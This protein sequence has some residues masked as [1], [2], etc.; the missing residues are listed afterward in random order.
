MSGR[1]ARQHRQQ[2][3]K[4][5]PALR[6][7][8][9]GRGFLS[10]L[11]ML[12]FS[13]PV[14]LTAFGATAASEPST[15]AVSGTTKSDTAK[16]GTAKPDAPEPAASLLPRAPEALVLVRPEANRDLQQQSVIHIHEDSAGF[17]WLLTQ[18]AVHRFDGQDLI[19]LPQPGQTDAARLLGN[20]PVTGI[21]NGPEGELWLATMGEGLLRFDPRSGEF[22]SGAELGLPQSEAG[23]RIRYLAAS[24]QGLYWLTPAGL[25]FR[26]A[27]GGAV[28]TL[29]HEGQPIDAY[30]LWTVGDELWV[31]GVSGLLYRRGEAPLSRLADAAVQGD[32]SVLLPGR[33]G[34]LFAFGSYGAAR[35]APGATR[36]APLPIAS[37]GV[38]RSA[39]GQTRAPLVSSAV[40][41]ADGTLWLAMPGGGLLERRSDGREFVHTHAADDPSGIPEPD[42]IALALD[43]AGRLWIGSSSRGFYHRAEGHRWLRVLREPAGADATSRNN[44]FALADDGAGG[45]WIGTEGAGLKHRAA[46][47][48]VSYHNAALQAAGLPATV[49]RLR[50]FGGRLF[51]R[52]LLAQGD[53]LLVGGAQALWRYWPSQQRAELVLP[54]LLH[55]D[56]FNAGVRNLRAR[57]N[58]EV[59][60]ASDRSGLVVLTA[61]GGY[62]QY[63]RDGKGPLQLPTNRVLDALEDRAGQVWLAT[64]IGLF[65]LRDGQAPEPVAGDPERGLPSAFV[66]TLLET[67]TG[68]LWV[69]TFGGI[70]RLQDPA[71]VAPT[72][73]RYTREQGLRDNV[74]YALLE[75]ASGDIWASTNV[76]L[77]QFRPGTQQWRH[78]GRQDG[79][80]DDE[81][82]L[83]A[84]ARLGDGSLVFGGLTGV[85]RL[86]PALAPVPEARAAL[87]VTAVQIGDQRLQSWW[88]ASA[89][90]LELPPD[91]GALRLKVA[92]P[93]AAQLQRQRFFYRFDRDP[94]WTPLDDR[95]E[96][97]LAGLAA[98]QRRLLMSWSY[99]DEPTQPALVIPVNVVP[100]W[101]QRPLWQVLAV[102][103]VFS[104]LTWLWWSR[105]RRLEERLQG[106][107]ALRASDERLRLALW[108]TGDALWDWNLRT[109]RVSRTGMHTLLGYQEDDIE[110]TLYWR[111]KLLH[112]DDVGISTSALQRHLDGLATYYEAEYRLRKANGDWLWVLDRGQIVERDAHN[113]PLRMAGTM[114]DVSDR[115]QRDEELRFLANYDSL[116]GLPNRT[117]FHERLEHALVVARR[118][119]SRVAVLFIDLDRFKA[120]NDSFGHAVGDQLLRSVAR[121]L[122]DCVREEDTVARL[123]GDEFTVILEGVT[124]VSAITRVAESLL[125]VCSQPF[126]TDGQQLSISPSIGISVFPDDAVSAAR[127]VNHADMAMYVAKDQ[128]RNTYRYFEARMNDAALRRASISMA[129][130]GAR[131]AGEFSLHYQ[132]RM[133]IAS[134]AITGFEALL[135]WRS[136]TLGQVSP[137]EF[138]P[139]AEEIGLIGSIGDW[140]L[141]QVCAQLQRWQGGELGH[142]PVAVNVSIR[143]LI[144]GQ[145]PVRVAQLLQH[146]AVPARD[147]HIEITESLLMENADLAVETLNR[148]R[149]LGVSIAIDD[150]GTGYSSL[151]YLRRLPIDGLKI[152]QAFVRD[153]ADD[154][155]DAVIIQ[156]IIAMAHALK[157]NVIAEGVESIEQLSFLRQHGCDEM[158]GYL[159]SRPLPPE[160]LP[161]LLK[162]GV[163][164]ASASV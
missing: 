76:G 155:D 92:A 130:R 133:A 5:R 25:H 37:F 160:Q 125:Q 63:H 8:K 111:D 4:A 31:A 74:I 17:L 70:A 129:L 98:G 80:A 51:V 162:D 151:S 145:L 128:G 19:A 24:D 114:R 55:G 83:H 146:Y 159:L 153:L 148:V 93:G 149:G 7:R 22:R 99:G 150:F 123:G 30:R 138:I 26:P 144:D 84:A 29:L 141:E 79:L 42:V 11:L 117:L 126:E 86:Q 161:V 72:V 57:R 58:G 6:Q 121:R 43:R 127:L 85:S 67:S 103:L 48:R 90:E 154:R 21:S 94:R 14:L 147:L 102:A 15:T 77:M 38:T 16:P 35:R 44:V 116:T 53:S 28:Q 34:E 163:A 134:G 56:Q 100:W 49:K 62:R 20:V 107:Q 135:R 75:D 9:A 137:A 96:L 46:D 88:A 91:A 54:A 68:E 119:E 69:G 10:A 109:G 136:A 156:T 112:P 78:W 140:V 82:N 71:A 113:Q 40:I 27:G 106:E 158:Q 152:D 105:Q 73:S 89:P 18:S 139:V 12:V 45:L 32:T 61:D 39:D 131:D 81:F 64:D 23:K 1:E 41:E 164:Q 120:I 101:W 142:L 143:Q 33:D 47:G 157:L 97:A 3:R 13:L 87:R 115:H 65:R 118:R 108:G 50:P 124:H 122:R 52:A 59:L 60:V 95:H 104:V 66:N 110:D 132:P 36:F 2:E